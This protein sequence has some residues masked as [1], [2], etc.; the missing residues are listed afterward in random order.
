MEIDLSSLPKWINSIYWRNFNDRNRFNLYYG[1]A[2]SGK[3]WAIIGQRTI[4]RAITTPGRNALVLRKVN[5]T[6]KNSTFSM[7]K[8]ILSQWGMR[9]FFKINETDQTLECLHNENRIICSGLDDPEKVKSIITP[10]GPITDVLFEEFTEFT[11]SDFTQLNLR[12]RGS[13]I[14]G[15]YFQLTGCFN[16]TDNLH[17]I[18]NVFFDSTDYHDSLLIVQ[19]THLDNKYI[20]AEYRSEFERMKVTDPESYSVYGLG[21]WTA[22]G[23]RVLSNWSVSATNKNLTWY[24]SVCYGLDFGFNHYQSLIVA[25]LKD[26][27]IYLIYE[28]AE[29]G[30]TNKEFM[31]QAHDYLPKNEKCIAD[32]ANPDKIKEWGQ[33]GYRVVAA[34]KG[35]GSLRAGIDHLKSCHLY[36]DDKTCPRILEEIKSYS[37]KKD[38]NG[39]PTDMPIEVNDDCID[40]LRY[41]LEDHRRGVGMFLR[42]LKDRKKLDAKPKKTKK[43]AKDILDNMKGRIN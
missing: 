39:N 23:D 5:R 2:G 7:L 20:D 24:D 40:A 18:K 27:N 38:S 37:W 41:A 35:P 17:W 3:S 33:A 26:G 14:P 42:S 8:L 21:L 1:G 13:L 31:D 36:I 10:N 15:L 25:G 30:L 43:T 11:L 6:S 28:L 12:L 34:N 32:S 22:K 16:P 29:R 19:T 4:Y 9:D